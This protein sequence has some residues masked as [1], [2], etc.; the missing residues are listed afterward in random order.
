MQSE[1]NHDYKGQN[2]CNRLHYDYMQSKK[3]PITDYMKNVIDYNQ[4]RLPH[5]C[6]ISENSSI[7][8]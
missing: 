8:Q 5:V 2:E 7:D 6:L 4:L 3:C 1:S